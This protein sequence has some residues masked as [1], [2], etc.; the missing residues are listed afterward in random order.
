MNDMM[1]HEGD[2]VARGGGGQA[3]TQGKAYRE[4]YVQP[5]RVPRY[6]LV[7]CLSVLFWLMVLA[8]VAAAWWRFACGGA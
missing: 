2:G 6:R 4:L 1:R 7:R 8:L 3:G 5:V